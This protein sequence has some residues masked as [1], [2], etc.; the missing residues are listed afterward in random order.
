MP[1]MGFF[2]IVV[3]GLKFLDWKGFAKSYAMY[4]LIAM[5]SKFYAWAYPVIELFLGVSYLK[6]NILKITAG[7][8]F[9]LM[10]ISVVGVTKSLSSKKKLHCACLGTVI[11]L[12]LTKFTLFE[13]I[14]MGIMSL[15]ILFF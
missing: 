7:I 8:T 3:S 14:T 12:P 10:A 15:I 11:K 6:L 5:K 1:F 4:D 13:N 9:V 2:F